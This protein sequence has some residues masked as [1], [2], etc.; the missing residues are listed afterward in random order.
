MIR[1]LGRTIR[2]QVEDRCGV[3]QDTPKGPLIWLFWHNRVFL[4][5]YLQQKVCPQRRGRVLT[6]S[7]RDGE[8]I[9]RIM[10]RFGHGAVR[11]SS[12]KRPAAALREMVRM[13]GHGDDIAITPDGPRGPRYQLQQGAVKLA[14]LSGCPLM[15][16]HVTYTRAWRLKTWDQFVI[17]KPFTSAR[18]TFDALVHVPR[19][20]SDT[21]AE[22]IRASLEASMRRA[23]GDT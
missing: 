23:A 12:N 18:L 8:I 19:T 16:V 5:P 21:E 3:T 2:V 1:L 15:C 7:S 20:L 22:S 10:R 17:P 11:G 6:S 4:M 13:L 14:Q 9:A